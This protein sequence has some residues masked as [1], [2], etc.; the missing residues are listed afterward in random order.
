MADIIDFEQA[1]RRLHGG[2]ASG[3]EDNESALRELPSE[4]LPDASQLLGNVVFDL[5]TS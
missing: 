3:F 1:S 4:V 2:D 5:E